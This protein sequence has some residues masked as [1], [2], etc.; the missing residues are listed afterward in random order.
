MI[1]N[2]LII[3]CFNEEGNIDALIKNCEKFIN[4]N[5]NELILVNNGSADKTKNKILEYKKLYNNIFVLNIDKNIGF[6]H[7]VLKG[8]EISKGQ[9][10][11]YTHADPE[12]DQLDVTKGIALIPNDKNY[13]IKG[14]RIN[15][16]LNKW[17]I[18]DR[19]IS[20][21]LS[22]IT[23]LLFFKHIYDLHAQP[24]IFNRELIKHFNKPPND[25]MFDIYIY[26][27]AMRRK[28]KVIR[29]AVNFNKSKRKYGKGSNDT[30]SK[31]ISGIINHLIKLLLLRIKIN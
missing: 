17:S 16:K 2:S 4:Q 27:L 3:P 31:K 30:I 12:V 8:I 29:F 19:I 28:Y 7:G 24:V 1:K 14:N 25:F 11:I 21:S 22:V 10:I 23:S 13:F 26:L 9:T 6:G 18:F 15:R 20:S 5:D